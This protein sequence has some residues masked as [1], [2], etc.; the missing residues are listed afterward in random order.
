MR[1]GDVRTAWLKVLGENAD[2]CGHRRGGEE[3]K[4]KTETQIEMK[5][6]FLGTRL[7]NLVDV[8]HE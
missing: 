3:E 8:R 7:L 1:R 6:Y 2:T 5:R 4:E